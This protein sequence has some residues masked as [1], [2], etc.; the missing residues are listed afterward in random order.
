MH[1]I[2][3]NAVRLF[4]SASGFFLFTMGLSICDWKQIRKIPGI[5]ETL[6]PE[7]LGIYNTIQCN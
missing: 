3:I 5:E 6:S 7:G 2:T 1:M 4:F